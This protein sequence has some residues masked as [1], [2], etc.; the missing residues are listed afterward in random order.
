[1]VNTDGRCSLIKV[2][3]NLG[4]SW[5]DLRFISEIASCAG[6]AGRNPRL[7]PRSTAIMVNKNCGANMSR[8]AVKTRADSPALKRA[9]I[10]IEQSAWNALGFLNFTRAHFQY[11][12]ELAGALRRLPDL[13]GRR[14]HRL[15]GGGRLLR[16]VLLRRPQRP[17]RRRL[18]LDRRIAPAEPTSPRNMLGGA[19][20]LGAAAFTAPRG[21]RAL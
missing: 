7:C 20:H 6:M 18:G 15:S 1:M 16:A 2:N 5:L 14:S 12:D 9:A 3:K 8:Y 13:P 19:R 17:A 21:S 10:A 4:L 11:Y